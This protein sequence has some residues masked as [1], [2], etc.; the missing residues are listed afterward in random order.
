MKFVVIQFFKDD[1]G[2]WH[3]PGSLVDFGKEEAEL[4]LSRGVIQ[5]YRTQMVR[6]VE[7]RRRKREVS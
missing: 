4:Y 7:T 5:S 1:S 2:E 3:Q 6:P